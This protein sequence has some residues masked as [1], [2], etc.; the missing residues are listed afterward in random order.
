M[1]GPTTTGTVIA[2]MPNPHRNPGPL[3]IFAATIPAIH[4][5]I[6]YGVVANASIRDRDFSAVVSAMKTVKQ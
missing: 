6:M 5:V 1:S 4:V 3:I 2:N